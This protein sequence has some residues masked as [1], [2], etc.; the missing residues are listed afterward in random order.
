MGRP[1]SEGSTLTDISLPDS[2]FSSNVSET[3][4]HITE[5]PRI[6]IEGWVSQSK[7][8]GTGDIPDVTFEPVINDIRKLKHLPA[9]PL[10][11]GDT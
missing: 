6:S 7:G 11:L 5:P 10:H 9:P 1:S 8:E 4:S 3:A 2:I